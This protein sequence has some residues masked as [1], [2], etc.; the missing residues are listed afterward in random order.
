MTKK[1]SQKEVVLNRLFR[2]GR[3]DN[4]WAINNYILRL[5]AV[6][7]DLKREGYKINGMFGREIGKPK[8]LH[9]NYYYLL[10]K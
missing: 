5:G 9:K 6:I 10:V 4:F 3:V 8:N 2:Y 7:W 1:L